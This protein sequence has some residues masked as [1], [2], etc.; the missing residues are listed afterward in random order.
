MFGPACQENKPVFAAG[1]INA[2]PVVKVQPELKEHRVFDL[3]L[4][5]ERLDVADDA[6]ADPTDAAGDA[7]RSRRALNGLNPLAEGIPTSQLER[8][9]REGFC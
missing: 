1:R 2:V 8:V 9:E 3:V 6:L 5:A 4:E 7:L